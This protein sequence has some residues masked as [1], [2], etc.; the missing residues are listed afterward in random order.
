MVE[1]PKIL[2][3]KV[4]LLVAQ[5]SNI[6]LKILK[7]PMQTQPLKLEIKIIKHGQEH[8]AIMVKRAEHI[9]GKNQEVTAHFQLM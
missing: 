7:L 3:T 6:T 9:F 2:P 1:Q 8:V 4:Q 5:H